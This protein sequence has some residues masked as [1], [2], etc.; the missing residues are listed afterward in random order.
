[1]VNYAEWLNEYEAG[2]DHLEPGELYEQGVC[3]PLE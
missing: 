2:I 3:R 1:M